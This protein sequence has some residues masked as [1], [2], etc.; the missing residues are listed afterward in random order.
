MHFPTMASMG[1]QSTSNRERKEEENTR[2]LFSL[3][4][5]SPVSGSDIMNIFELI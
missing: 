3:F 5:T 1:A 4:A 2:F